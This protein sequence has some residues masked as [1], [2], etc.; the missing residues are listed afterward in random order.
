MSSGQVSQVSDKDGVV[1]PTAEFPPDIWGDCFLNYNYEEDKID[2]V[3]REEEIEELK[4]QV[5][6]ELQSIVNNP[7][8]KQNNLVDIVERL[9]V[10]RHFKTEIKHVLQH[11]YDTYYHDIDHPYDLCMTALSFRLLRQHGSGK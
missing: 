5:R 8:S 1:R 7:L 9:G 4:E 2:H 11:I 10:E 3:R 6:M